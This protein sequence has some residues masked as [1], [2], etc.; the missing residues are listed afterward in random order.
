MVG[1]EFGVFSAETKV[2]GKTGSAGK[3]LPTCKIMP[4]SVELQTQASKTFVVSIKIFSHIP[5]V[6]LPQIGPGLLGLE[7]LM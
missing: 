2:S 6:G 1:V 5:F 7:L 3:K 4:G